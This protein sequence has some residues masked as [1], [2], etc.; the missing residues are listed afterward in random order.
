MSYF[1]PKNNLWSFIFA[2]ILIVSSVFLAPR[3]VSADQVP[4]VRTTE[5]FAITSNSAAMTGIVNAGGPS[6]FFRFEYA[7]QGGAEI[8]T[9]LRSAGV[10]SYR[11]S[12]AL[13]V[14]ELLP[15]TTYY[16][17][18]VAGNR[19]G[20]SAGELVSFKTLP[21]KTDPNNS[22]QDSV[23]ESAPKLLNKAV[24]LLPFNKGSS[25][26]TARVEPAATTTPVTDT[27]PGFWAGVADFFRAIW[28][29]IVRLWWLFL[30][31]LIG[32]IA[33]TWWLFFHKN[34]EE[35]GSVEEIIL[36]ARE[37]F[38]RERKAEVDLGGNSKLPKF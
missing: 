37:E 19:L 16:Y 7:P 26:S 13:A 24:S 6:A 3:S 2:A 34:K 9:E 18:I 23:A 17:R 28:E 5:P 32:I 8:T 12:V 11:R 25:T 15:D 38:D 33:L 35:E 29:F 20:A 14:Q 21:A 1:F 36:R 10:G 4:W 22:P 31:I 27:G 30:L